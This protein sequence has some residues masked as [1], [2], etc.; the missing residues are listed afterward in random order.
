MKEDEVA[1]VAPPYPHPTLHIHAL[2]TKLQ[3]SISNL[4]SYKSHPPT[5]STL[6]DTPD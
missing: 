1:T 2:H 5:P 4:T 3:L 6:S